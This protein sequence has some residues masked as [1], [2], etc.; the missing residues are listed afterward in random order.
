MKHLGKLAVLGAVLA[1]SA[2]FASATSTPLT[3]AIN[4]YS[5]PATANATDG[6]FDLL[7]VTNPGNYQGGSTFP[8]LGNYDLNITLATTNVNLTAIGSSGPTGI[9]IYT[10]ANSGSDI[11]AFWATGYNS[12]G[13]ASNSGISVDLTGYF[14]DGGVNFANTAGVDDVTYNPGAGGVSQPSITYQ[15]AVTSATPEPS[16]LLL[17]G[18]GLIG[19]AG[20]MVRKRQ[21]A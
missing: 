12:L 6:G 11:L 2:P 19:A 3:G 17:L 10:A 14:T 13:P 18:T 9:E 7:T 1:A 4:L 21:T 15:L 16:S 8:T 20:I 5:V